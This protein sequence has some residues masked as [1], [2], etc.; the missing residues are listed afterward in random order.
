M[1]AAQAWQGR[2]VPEGPNVALQFPLQGGEYLVANGGTNISV[3]SHAITFA[4][5]SERQRRYYGQSHAVDIVALTPLGLTADGVSPSDPGS[6]AIFG[7]AVLAPCDGQVVGFATDRPDMQ[8]PIMDKQ[9]MVGNHVLLRCASADILLAHFRRGSVR[10]RPGQRVR[11][12]EVL[13]E[14]GNSGNSSAPHLH[15]HAQE[16]GP[17]DAPFSGKPLPMTIGGDYLV[18]GDRIEVKP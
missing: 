16:P 17:P 1:T 15:I 10:V 12:R 9:N 11:V 3:S 13:G 18:R 8:V 2:Q 4:R 5:A 14:A 7:R 6:H